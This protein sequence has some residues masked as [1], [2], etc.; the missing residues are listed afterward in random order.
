MQFFAVSETRA[1]PETQP[2]CSA[3][4]ELEFMASLLLRANTLNKFDP[5]EPDPNSNQ[6]RILFENSMLNGVDRHSVI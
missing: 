6:S 3:E 1:Y 5:I 2:S 4:I